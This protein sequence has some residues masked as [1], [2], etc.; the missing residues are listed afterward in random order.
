[1][2]DYYCNLSADTF[3]DRTGLDNSANVLTGPAGLQAAIRG[4]GSA[5]ALTAGDTIHLKGSGDLSRLV[6][7]DCGADVSAWSIGDAVSENS[8]AGA[9]T[10]VVVKTS[11]GGDSDVVLVWMGSG[12]DAADV[13][14]AGGIANPGGSPASVATLTSVSTPGITLDGAYGSAGSKVRFVGV[15]DSWVEDRTP[16]TLDAGDKAA[17]CLTNPATMYYLALANL[18]LANAAGDCLSPVASYRYNT[19][20]NCVFEG[21]ASDGVR[22]SSTMLY[23]AFDFCTFRDNGDY[24]AYVSSCGFFGCTFY[25][26]DTGLYALAAGA[27]VDCV[28]FENTTLGVWLQNATAAINC[29]MDSNDSGVRV[30]HPACTVTACRITNNDSYGIYGSP[31]VRD[32]YCFYSGNT[33]NFENDI[34]D[35][36][37]RGESTRITSGEIGYIDGDN[38]DLTLRNYGLTNSATS[39]RQEA[40]L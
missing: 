28:F 5:T 37:V 36:T 17:S 35:A 26:N 40:V 7:I 30:G 13:L 21:A 14:L 19:H 22:G 12:Y 2:T 27:A 39:R 18:V 16:A 24:G 32:A 20:T 1:M 9:W 34:H 3:A 15:N 8:G 4:T 6:E 25:N 10:G 31:S 23:C 33:A 38:A 29:V 11:V